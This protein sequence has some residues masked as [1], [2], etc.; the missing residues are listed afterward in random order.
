[1]KTNRNTD[2][3]SFHGVT[4]TTTIDELRQLLDSPTYESYCE[5]SPVSI[6]WDCETDTK[7]LFTIYDYDIQGINSFSK[8]EFNIGAFNWLES[9]EAK[10]YLLDCLST[11]S[12]QNNN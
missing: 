12:E 5:K 3:T 1:M 8:T 2:G 9:V 4:I 6:A 7:T 11:L 10:H